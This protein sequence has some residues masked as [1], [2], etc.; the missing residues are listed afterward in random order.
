MLQ[1]HESTIHRIFVACVVLVETIFPCFNLKPDDCNLAT[2]TLVHKFP[3]LHVTLIQT[4]VGISLIKMGLIS[5][6]IYPGSMSDFDI[7]KKSSMWLPRFR[8]I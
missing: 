6:K 8:K 7:T 3:Q 5:S 4:L 2:T 1:I